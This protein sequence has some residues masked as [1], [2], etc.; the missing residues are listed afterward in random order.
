MCVGPQRSMSDSASNENPRQPSPVRGAEGESTSDSPESARGRAAPS[1]N[2]PPTIISNRPPLPAP[3]KLASASA[4]EEGETTLGDRL[5]DYELLEYIGGGGM[6]RV[7]R[8]V[9]SRL[10]RTVAVKVLSREQAADE[11]TLL[12]FRNEARS[13]ARLDHENIARVYHAGED[14]G[15]PYIAFEFVEGENLR[16]RVEQY[17]ALPLGE[18]VSYTLQISDALAHAA[19]RNVVHRDIKPSNLLITPEGRVKVIDTGLARMRK[20]DPS[21]DDLTASGV[22]LGTFDYISPEQARDPRNTDVRSDIYSLGCTFFYMLTGRPPFPEGTVLQKLLQHQ[23]DDPPDL[24]QFRP[25]LPEEVCRVLRKMLA[26]DPR[27]RYQEPSQLVDDLVSLAEQMGLRP[28]GQGGNVWVVP[29]ESRLSFL[30]QHFPWIA[31]IAA[32]VCIVMLLD[33]LWSTSAR[34]ETP[35]PSI[36][37]LSDSPDGPCVASSAKPTS[38]PD[39]PPRKA[40]DKPPQRS[41]EP[42]AV[43]AAVP[44]GEADGSPVSGGDTKAPEPQTPEGA[45]EPGDAAPSTAVSALPPN[46][47]GLAPETIAGGLSAAEPASWGLGVALEAESGPAEMTAAVIPSKPIT[48]SATTT[49]TPKRAGLLIVNDDGEGDDEFATLGAACNAAGNGDVIELRYNGRRAQNPIALA[50]LRVTVRAGEGF[51]PAVVFRPTESDPVKYPRS[52]FTLTASRLTMINVALELDVP[53]KVPAESWSLLTTDR[54]ETVRL[55]R[56]SLTIRNASDQLGAYHQDVAFFRLK[57]SPGLNG[58]APAELPTAAQ[59]A[60]IELA[61]CI[62]RGEATFLRVEDLQ[63]VQL[64]WE[65]GLLVTS[66]RFLS[67]EGGEKP[68]TSEEMIRITLRHVTAVVRGGLYWSSNG[69][70][71]P[72]QLVTRFNCADSIL[73]GEPMAPMIDQVGV[74]GAEQARERL[75]WSGDRCFYEGFEVF[76]SIRH[77][78]PKQG[79][80]LFDFETWKSYWEPEERENLPMVGRVGWQELPG[81]DSTLHT[82]APA[83]YALAGPGAENPAHGAAS[84]GSDVGFQADRLPPLPADPPA[85]ETD[86]GQS[87]ER[88]ASVSPRSASALI[89]NPSGASLGL[90]VQGD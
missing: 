35:P 45:K 6:G 68:P 34:E 4:S 82:H 69:K 38:K 39:V 41:E 70:F 47:H 86:I 13:A 75:A 43:T 52:M 12:R 16:K 76:W 85:E 3:A 10:A 87:A 2:D 24:R 36:N 77:L 60:R 81:A 54:A 14:R 9:D 5:G 57:A 80:E 66:E 84:D 15:L 48:G 62:V 21:S 11:E 61:D 32:L 88:P 49:P 78:D 25:E 65:N 59:L 73:L 58:A 63:A 44:P 28:A 31:P 40:P 56:C 53:R 17:G 42:T 83:D 7:F 20:V 51:S 55:E 46:V 50:N 1:R 27:H 26:K 29:R 90:P 33:F 23:G 72:Y 22:T 37:E 79:A 64:A 19:S 67:A 8:A 71:T 74:A 18:A 30:G 89:D